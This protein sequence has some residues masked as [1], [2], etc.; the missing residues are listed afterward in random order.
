MGTEA[1]SASPR[2]ATED[3]TNSVSMKPG[4]TAFTRTR[5]AAYSSAAVFVRPLIACLLAL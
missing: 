2:V 5:A 4:Q 1:S 3:L